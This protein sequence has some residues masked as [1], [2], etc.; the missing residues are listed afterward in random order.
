[1]NFETVFFDLDDTLY[2]N[3]NGLWEAIRYRMSLYM[4]ERLG[5]SWDII[6]ELRH[7]YF[8]TYGTTLRG[9]QLHFKVDADEYLD[10]VHDLPLH[11]YLHPDNELR[12]M[13]ESIPLRKFIFTNADA[14]HAQRV[15]KEIGLDGCFQS[16]IDVRAINFHCKPEPEA[17]QLALQI[18]Q[19]TDP[20]K[21][22]YLDDS[23]S[24]LA[25][26]HALGMYTILV[27]KIESHPKVCLSIHHIKDLQ[28]QMPALW[29]NSHHRVN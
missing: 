17:Y 13:I 4:H 1:M 7:H 14:K 15:L 21:C 18:A 16:I 2:T 24:N 20:T 9:L 10:Y 29:L 6:P 23:V 25:P 19:I 26:A 5:L 3:Q 27:G 28:D 11:E 22:V 8:V 12:E